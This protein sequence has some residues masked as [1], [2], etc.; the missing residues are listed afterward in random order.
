[1][2][3]IKIAVYWWSGNFYRIIIVIFTT[4]KFRVI[5]FIFMHVFV[6]MFTFTTSSCHR[7]G[8]IS[9]INNIFRQTLHEFISKLMEILKENIKI[10]AKSYIL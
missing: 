1:M 2:L 10:V 4:T 6:I 7:P 9:P 3:D 8:R 5:R